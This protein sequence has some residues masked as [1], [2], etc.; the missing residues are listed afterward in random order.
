MARHNITGQQ[1]EDIVADHLVS[2]G[3]A[4]AERN[5]RMGHNEID[6]IAIKDT[7]I[8]FVEV[9][10][11]RSD[12]ID[13]LLAIDRKKIRHLA[14]AAN[15]YIRINSIRQTPRFDVATVILSEGEP[16]IEYIEDAFLPPLR[17]Y[18]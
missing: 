9:K 13:P 6:I 1:G 4:I 2:Q 3:Y 11:R 8:A 15:A 12:D 17:T 18:R 5:Y 7:E 16:T 14:S 10:T